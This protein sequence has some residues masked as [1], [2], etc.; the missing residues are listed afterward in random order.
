MFFAVASCNKNSELQSYDS[1][2]E[3]EEGEGTLSLSYNVGSTTRATTLSDDDVN[4]LLEDYILKIYK[5]KNEAAV[6]DGVSY[7]AEW[8]LIRYY[9]PANEVPDALYLV[10]GDYKATVSLQIDETPVYAAEDPDQYTYSGSQEFAIV[11]GST[12][13]IEIACSVINSVVRVVYDFSG[14]SGS[15]LIGN[16]VYVGD[17]L[18]VD[19]LVTYVSASNSFTSINDVKEN[20]T[21]GYTE[22]GQDGYFVCPEDVTRL[23]WGTFFDFGDKNDGAFTEITKFGAISDPEP[24]TLY[25]INLKYSTTTSGVLSVEVIL[26]EEGITEFDDS[27]I[28][29]PQPTI[30]GDGISTEFTYIDGTKTYSIQSLQAISQISLVVNGTTLIPLANGE[31]VEGIAGVESVSLDSD[32]L[33]GSVTLNSDFFNMFGAGGLQSFVVTAVD[34]SG[35]A[36]TESPKVNVTGMLETISSPDYWYNTATLNA[37]VTNTSESDVKIYCRKKG[38]E[39]WYEFS[40]AASAG[41]TFSAAMTPQWSK[42]VNDFN[43]NIST[44]DLGMTVGGEYETKLLVNGVQRGGITTIT[45]G[46]SVQTITSANMDG[47]LECF[48]SDSESSTT[49]GSGNNTFTSSLCTQS[50]RGGSNAAKLK[51]YV[52]LSKFAAGNLFFGQFKFNGIITQT[53]TVR[54]GQAFSWTA[55]PRAIK[56]RYSVQLATVDMD[57]PSEVGSNLVDGE[58]DKARIF[59]CVVNWSSRHNVTSG[60]GDPEGVWDP[61]QQ[62][63]VD[64]G[65]IIGYASKFLTEST[66]T[67]MYEL[68]IP[69][70]WYDTATKPTGAISLVISAATSAYGDYMVGGEG[71][72]LWVDDWEF[73]Y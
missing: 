10:S 31:V 39:D 29:S 43:L 48:T 6:V 13:N 46:G 65:N 55:R 72:E 21:L 4:T 56:L 64:E 9:Y 61:E 5:L 18:I 8:E 44:L 47:S 67:N 20:Y 35:T 54:F 1:S 62:M 57:V 38:T 52:V 59:A 58:L 28:F 2:G 33:T 26:N 60:S 22:S 50:S 12:S 70:Y 23:S 14:I 27:F 73:V 7:D 15:E 25:T 34:E 42:A 69:F 45:A 68:E 30:S 40:A 11:A 24:S 41:T 51:S 36:G 53:G 49:W 3:T 19:N 16:Q 63:S 66:D 37:M 17:E 32:K 71:T